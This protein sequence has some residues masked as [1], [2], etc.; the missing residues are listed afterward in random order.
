MSNIELRWESCSTLSKQF[1]EGHPVA[2]RFEWAVDSDGRIHIRSSKSPEIFSEED[3][4]AM[5][6]HVAGN[7]TG[8]PLGARRDGNVPSNSLG[9]LMEQR[10][11]TSS[12][13]GWCSHLAAIAV[14]QGHLLYEDKGRGPGRGI[15]LYPKGTD[16]VDLQR[17]LPFSVK[18]PNEVTKKALEDA[19]VRR[20]LESF[21][22]VDDL[23][24]DLGI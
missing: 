4:R 20:N 17:G 10:R 16:L 18:V 15:W 13:R 22:S 24:E 14:Q 3:Y 11:N 23:F 2:K 1:R 5:I 8:V 12:I 7:P 9:A 21:D 6:T 19:R